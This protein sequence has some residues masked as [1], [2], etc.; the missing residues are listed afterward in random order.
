MGKVNEGDFSSARPKIEPEDL[1]GDNAVLEADG[2]G[3]EEFDD[4]TAQGGKR[5]AA[6]LTFVEFP[7]E[8]DA[9][10]GRVCWLNVTA[11]RAI[12]HHYGDES[13][14]WT[15]NLFP[16][17]IVSGTAFGKAYTKVQVVT[18]AEKW[19]DFIDFGEPS[20][21]PKTRVRKKKTTRKSKRGK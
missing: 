5:K 19:G 12:I 8:G 21:P 13:D 15:G 3:E 11:I 1:D 10:M 20:P 7:A 17:E 14:D 18:P 9:D 4:P 6:Y 16:V 2:Y